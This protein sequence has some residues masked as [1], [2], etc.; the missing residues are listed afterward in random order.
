MRGPA[1][2]KGMAMRTGGRLNRRSLLPARS[3]R[4]SVTPLAYH[5][6]ENYIGVIRE[7]TRSMA[8]SSK[9]GRISSTDRASRAASMRV[10]GRARSERITKTRQTRLGVF[11]DN[12][13]K[14]IHRWYPFVEGF[15]AD[16]VRIALDHRRLD[17]ALLD[18]F[19]GSGTTALAAAQAGHDSYFCEVNPYLAWVTDVKVNQARV[20][21][22]VGAADDIFALADELEQH[23]VLSTSSQ[24]PLLVADRRRGFFPRGVAAKIIT[25]LQM[26]D[27]RC[28]PEA[29][30]LARLAVATSLIPASRMIRRT[31]LRRRQS[32][33]PGPQPFK[34]LVIQR[35]REIAS[36]VEVAGSE[37]RGKATHAAEDARSLCPLPAR[38]DLIVTSPPYLNG[39]NYCRNT[40]LELLALGLVEDEEDLAE[41]RLGSIAA[42]INTISRR[43]GAAEVI[44]SVERVACALDKVAYDSRVPAMV[45]MYFSDMGR[46]FAKIRQNS[47]HGACFL[48]DIGDSRFCGIHIATHE[49]L[50]DVAS[51]HGWEKVDIETIR[52]RRSYDGTQLTQVLIEFRAA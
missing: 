10:A 44:E 36:D 41:L 6:V 39:T 26:I 27:E 14:P 42:G 8:V 13:R 49:L 24:H 21:W 20:A 30:G 48:L 45:R 16:L 32:G 4:V 23:R 51:L 35:L 50:C 18:P 46:V 19:G 47:K 29:A 17:G 34:P 12:R 3:L 31:D 7:A 2:L 52:P 38:I 22:K 5:A 25:A 28:R 37:I 33:D 9:P 11:D 1:T 43:R 40:K 15:S